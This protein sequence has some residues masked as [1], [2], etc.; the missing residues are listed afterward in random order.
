M[1]ST[2]KRLLVITCLGAF[3][4]VVVVGIAS[5]AG[6]G[7][8]GNRVAQGIAT[9]PA[10]VQAMAN[11]FVH[12]E[13]PS[14][15]TEKMGMDL[16]I[17]KM[18]LIGASDP[19]SNKPLIFLAHFDTPGVSADEMSQQMRQ[20]VQQQGGT[21]GLNMKVVETRK[22]TING[23]E[24]TLTVSEGSDSSG[25]SLR[26]WVTAFPAKKGTVLLL[27]QGSTEEWDDASLNAFLAS[28]TT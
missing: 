9:E 28:I 20:S 4:C 12:Y 15:Y 5:V 18:I 7:Y 16:V 27:I 19:S 25:L 10:T 17:Y 22:V 3:L 11:E 2:T 14:G 26:Q 6:I 24:T 8:I 23:Q 21:S 1:S 13:L